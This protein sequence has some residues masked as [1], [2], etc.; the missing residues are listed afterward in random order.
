MLETISSI[1]DEASS[2]AAACALAP[3]DTW[4]EAVEMD[5]LA[6]DTS[7]AMERMSETVCVSPPPSPPAPASACPAASARGCHRQVAVGNL[8]G[9][10][11]MSF[12]AAISVFR[13]FLIRLKSPW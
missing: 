7:P 5:W 4:I 10:R 8:L 13:L 12:M 1:D 2:A 6:A 9:R 3:F 11:V